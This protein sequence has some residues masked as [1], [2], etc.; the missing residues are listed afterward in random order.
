MHSLSTHVSSADRSQLIGDIS[1]VDES[2]VGQES[3]P[4]SAD[5]GQGGAYSTVSFDPV[6]PLDP[7]ICVSTSRDDHE[8][9]STLSSAV[10]EAGGSEA[11]AISLNSVEIGGVVGYVKD[12][13]S[14]PSDAITICSSMTELCSRP[15]FY[16][17]LWDKYCDH[18]I[19]G[20]IPP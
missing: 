17:A 4:G 9:Q 13:N 8:I 6:Q 12:N 20:T 2:A 5:R 3:L 10:G 11:C 19:D 15:T 1:R 18:F 7:G 16:P 14:G